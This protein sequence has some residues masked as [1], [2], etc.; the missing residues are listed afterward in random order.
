MVYLSIIILISSCV[1]YLRSSCLDAQIVKL[2]VTTFAI[3][4]L[5]RIKK[6]KLYMY[7]LYYQNNS[8]DFLLNNLYAIFSLLF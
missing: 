3:L 6:N 5:L 2:K 4:N 1:Y 7:I 8:V